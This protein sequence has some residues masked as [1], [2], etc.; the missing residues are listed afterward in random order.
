MNKLGCLFKYVLLIS[1][2]VYLFFAFTKFSQQGD[3]S[4]CERLRITISD[5]AHA[6][7]ITAAETER[8]IRKAGLDPIGRPMDSISSRAIEVSLLKNPFI[9][10]V[11]CYKT[12][13]RAL[14]VVV[15]QR[16]P[17]LRIIADNGEDYYI[18]ENGYTMQPLGYVADLCVATGDIDK[19]FTRNHLV[20]VGK[21]LRDNA[22]WNDQIEQ[23]NVSPARKL[24]LIPRV[25][26]QIIHLGS[27]DSL[28]LKFKNLRAFYDG[29]MPTVGWN[30]YSEITLEHVNQVICKKREQK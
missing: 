13:D 12:P 28:E 25:G 2:A 20:R 11:T 26:D 5:S 3:H 24:D 23:I 7:F 9:K 6:G 8:L 22:F 21:Y 18:D 17:V 30:K 15:I 10:D 19:A 29:V 1:V 14:N 16:L 4:T 27:T